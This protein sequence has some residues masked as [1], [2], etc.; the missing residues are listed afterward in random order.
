MKSLFFHA[1]PYK[2]IFSIAHNGL[3]PSED[4][5]VKLCKSIEDA[6]LFGEDKDDGDGDCF[7]VLAVLLDV[8]TV[9]RYPE[10]PPSCI[11]PI[12]CYRYEGWIS[13]SHIALSFDDLEGFNYYHTQQL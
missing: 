6:V 2:N 9:E 13:P 12:Q 5:F 8:E 3:K 4:G 7:L 11:E 1:T 10:Q